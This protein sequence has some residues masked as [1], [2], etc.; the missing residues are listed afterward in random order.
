MH[1]ARPFGVPSKIALLRQVAGNCALALLCLCGCARLNFL[2]SPSVPRDRGDSETQRGPGFGPEPIRSAPDTLGDSVALCVSDSLVAGVTATA[3]GLVFTGDLAGEV[4]A[5]D[6]ADGRILWRAS[7]GQPIGG[8]VV[9]YAVGN[10]Q[11]VAVASGLHAPMTW[12]LKS[13]PAKLVVYSLQ[14]GG[15]QPP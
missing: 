5:F 8:G 10:D 6:A 15:R 9:S 2:K 14:I 11:Y 13:S 4:L 3:G 7:T 12:H 1:H